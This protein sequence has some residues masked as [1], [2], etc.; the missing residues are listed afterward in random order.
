[1][2]P[3]TPIRRSARVQPITILLQLVGPSPSVRARNHPGPHPGRVSARAHP[4]VTLEGTPPAL[5]GRHR[6]AVPMSVKVRAG[7]RRVVTSARTLVYR[8][9]DTIPPVRRTVDELLRVEFVD[10]AVVIAAQGLLALLPLLVVLAA[11]LPGDVTATS[12]DELKAVT[13]VDQASADLLGR[14]VA[15]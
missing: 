4:A 11:F 10:R 1:M 7:V 8:V 15:G 9:L 13:G 2:S 14:Q 6:Q 3:M 5:G 12:L